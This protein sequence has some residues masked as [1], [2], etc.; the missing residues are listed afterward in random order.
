MPRMTLKAARINVGL[1][2]SEAARRLN[3]SNK[4]LCNWERGT[5]MPKANK[6]EDICM[7]YAVSYDN[8]IF[9]NNKNA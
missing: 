5:S 7:L 8:L 4:T 6:I 1:T 3:I 2:Q 9:F